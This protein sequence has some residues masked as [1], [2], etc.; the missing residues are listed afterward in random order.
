MPP[1]WWSL[2]ARGWGCGLSLFQACSPAQLL[3]RP[4]LLRSPWQAL[5]SLAFILV[6]GHRGIDCLLC[7]Q[8]PCSRGLKE[9]SSSWKGIG[10]TQADET[11]TSPRPGHKGPEKNQEHKSPQQPREESEALTQFC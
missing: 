11:V 4:L 10:H 7:T 9:C 2:Q 1:A 5:W 3:P 8:R 6:P